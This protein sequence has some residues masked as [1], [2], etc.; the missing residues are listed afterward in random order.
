MKNTKTRSVMIKYLIAAVFCAV[1]GTVY[2]LFSHEVYTPFMYLAFLIPFVIGVLPHFLLYKARLPFPSRLS[3]C[4]YA[5]GVTALTVGSILQGVLV[6]YGTTNRF[7]PVYAAAGGI[8]LL[9]GI[10]GYVTALIRR[11]LT[12]KKAAGQ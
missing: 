8:L 2:E 4:L 7:M 10:T 5:F 11:R 9:S 3:E 6:I 1:F 12:I